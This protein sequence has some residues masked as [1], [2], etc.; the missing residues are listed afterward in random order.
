[1]SVAYCCNCGTEIPDSDRTR[2]CDRCKKILLP[3]IKFMDASTSSSVRRLISNEQNLRNAGV[4]DSGMDYLLK[5]CELHDKRKMQ[6]RME[7][8]AAKQAAAEQKAMEQP[9]EQSKLSETEIP[10][11]EPLNL[12]HKSYGTFLPA[13]EIVLVAVGSVLILWCIYML[14]GNKSFEIVPFACG[15]GAFFSA[16]AADVMRKILS[17]VEEIKKYFR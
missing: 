16:Y 6:E 12:I 13:A 17:D 14:I 1:M 4:T 11:D 2:L 5:V 15:V 3:F 7:R 10:L 8:D 9:P